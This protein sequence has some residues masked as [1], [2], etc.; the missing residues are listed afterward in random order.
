MHKKKDGACGALA[1]NGILTWSYLNFWKTSLSL[2]V[3]CL[4]GGLPIEGEQS[5]S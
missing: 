2:S 4:I 3:H 5:L 1:G